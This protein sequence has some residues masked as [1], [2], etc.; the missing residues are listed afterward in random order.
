[1][2]VVIAGPRTF[3]NYDKVC[4]AIKKSKFK[5][6]EV[7]SGNAKGADAL[8]EKWARENKKKLKLFPADWNNINRE[9]AVVKKNSWGKKYD[10]HAGFH[11]NEQM[12]MYADAL[13]AIDEG[14]GGTGNMIKLA[15]QYELDVFV[16]KVEEHMEDHEF[17]YEF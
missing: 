5:I 2:K 11:R 16:Y 6:T 8:G 1:M 13:I 10:A 3:D 7:V 4:D 15:K 17:G 14:T 12:A 9:G